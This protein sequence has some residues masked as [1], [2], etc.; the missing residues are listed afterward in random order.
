MKFFAALKTV[1]GLQSSGTIPLLSADG[2]SLLIDK[3][4]ILTRWAEHF[5]NVLNR[6]SSSNYKGINRLPQV[7]CNPLLEKTPTVSETVKAIKSLSSGK[8]QGSDAVPAEKYKLGGP[9]VAELL[10][11][12]WRKETIPQEVKDT[13]I[14]HLFKRQ[15]TS[16]VYDNYQG[17]CL[18]SVAGEILARILLNRL[19]EHL[20]QSGLLPE[21]QCEF[22]KDRDLDM[23]FTAMQLEEKCQK[24]IVDLYMTFVDITKAFDTVSREGLWKSMTNFGCPVKII[25]MVR[26]FKTMASVLIH[27]L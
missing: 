26:Q 5:D 23:I 9:P 8:A 13:S 7:E 12:M 2:T 6:P 3:E 21:S 27:S 10:Y 14:I 22:R 18:S 25:A 24:Q 11:I 19:N 20:E 4:A 1:Y 17:I 15:G 16:Q